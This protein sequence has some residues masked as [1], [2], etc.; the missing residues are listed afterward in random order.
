M[1]IQRGICTI[2]M[3]QF[4]IPAS[5]NYYKQLM[6][7]GSSAQLSLRLLPASA[8]NTRPL[9]PSYNPLSAAWAPDWPLSVA[10]W[11]PHQQ[12]WKEASPGPGLPSLGTPRAGAKWSG[13]HPATSGMIRS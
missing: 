3:P 12:G 1:H 11:L 13:A 5:S 8:A 9:S 7:V 10:A 4:R 6:T 2:T